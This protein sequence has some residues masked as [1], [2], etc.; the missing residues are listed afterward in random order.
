MLIQGHN[1]STREPHI[2]KYVN[3]LHHSAEHA[4]WR[5]PFCTATFDYEPNKMKRSLHILTPWFMAHDMKSRS[6]FFISRPYGS[7]TPEQ[8]P[9]IEVNNFANAINVFPRKLVFLLT[10]T[11]EKFTCGISKLFSG[12]ECL[13]PSSCHIP[14]IPKN[15]VQ[16]TE[17]RETKWTTTLPS[18]CKKKSNKMHLNCLLYYWIPP[19]C[20]GLHR[21]SSESHTSHSRIQTVLNHTADRQHSY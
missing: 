7:K 21:S 13:P 12:T 16:P 5:R 11:N 18:I 14:S 15:P 2:T 17:I 10:A 6:V 8:D 3:F 19:T 9:E 20:F 1:P 4:A